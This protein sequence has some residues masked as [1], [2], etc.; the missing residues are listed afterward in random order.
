MSSSVE[1]FPQQNLRW[2]ISFYFYLVVFSSPPKPNSIPGLLQEKHFCGLGE[3]IVE[4]W[5]GILPSSLLCGVR[6]RSLFLGNDNIPPSGSMSSWLWEWSL[7]AQGEGKCQVSVCENT[8]NPQ[9]DP[10]NS[11]VF[12]LLLFLFT[13]LPKAVVMALCAAAE[14]S[15]GCSEMPALQFLQ[16]SKLRMNVCKVPWDF[17]HW[18][19]SVSRRGFSDVAG[20]FPIYRSSLV[21]MC[22][23]TG[24]NISSFSN[25][26][27][28]SQQKSWRKIRGCQ[29]IAR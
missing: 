10:W 3:Y 28:G 4:L 19:W 8:S 6:M 27:I 13:V 17:W 2:L 5:G 7:K 11:H 20:F 23:M 9:H 16:K 15:N 22:W 24:I 26:A 12:L 29:H 1:G 14:Q 18:K 25:E 21:W